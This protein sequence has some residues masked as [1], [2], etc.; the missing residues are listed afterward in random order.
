[1]EIEENIRARELSGFVGWLAKFVLVAI[2]LAGIFF[3]L[4]VPQQIG[5]L[6]FNEQYMGLFLAS[7]RYARPFF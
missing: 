7:R 1:M 6:V 5:W 3:L 2:P 4:N